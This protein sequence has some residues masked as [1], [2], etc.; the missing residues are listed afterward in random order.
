MAMTNEEVMENVNE[1]IVHLRALQDH[2]DRIEVALARTLE[3]IVVVE[4]KTIP[5]QRF[6]SPDPSY[7]QPGSYKIKSEP[8]C[9]VCGI[10]FKNASGYVCNNPLCSNR[11]TCQT[12]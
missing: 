10:E 4:Q 7:M 6:G 3:R 12:S 2:L 11:I 8:K 1:L 9:M 5:L